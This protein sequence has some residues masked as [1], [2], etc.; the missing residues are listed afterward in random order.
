MTTVPL[1]YYGVHTLGP[2]N[3]LC[4]LLRWEERG[5]IIPVWLPPVEGS[6]LAVADAEWDPDRPDSHDLL[7]E[8]IERSTSGVKSIEISSYYNGTF[9]ATV[10][11]EDGEEYDARLSDALILA[12][13]LNLLVDADEAVLNQASMWISESDAHEFFGLDLPETNN[14]EETSASGDAKAD[15]DFASLMRSMGV[16]ASDIAIDLQGTDDTDV[17]DGSNGVE[18][19]KDEI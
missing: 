1:A 18:D 2:E 3:F 12:S 4:A 9:V 6:R 14:E 5:R 11:L 16:D 17:T 10:E 13:K 7:T 15:A 19:D 8:I